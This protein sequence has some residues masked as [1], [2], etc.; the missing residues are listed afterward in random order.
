MNKLYLKV[1]LVGLTV[2]VCRIRKPHGPALALRETKEVLIGVEKRHHYL[3]QLFP[4]TP[5]PAD[6]PPTE[7]VHAFHRDLRQER[8]DLYTEAG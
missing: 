8:G 6:W 1:L 3:R 7:G 5:R 4:V 2:A